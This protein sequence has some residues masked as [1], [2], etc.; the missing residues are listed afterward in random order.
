LTYVSLLL[1]FYKDGVVGTTQFALTAFNAIIFFALDDGTFFQF[2]YFQ[3]FLGAEVDTDATTFAPV[4]IKFE[5]H[6]T[7]SFSKAV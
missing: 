1:L 6:C 7:T 3:N 5:T 4:T 2:C